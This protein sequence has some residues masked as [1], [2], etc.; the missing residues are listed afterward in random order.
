MLSGDSLR[1]LSPIGD[2]DRGAEKIRDVETEPVGLGDSGALQT[3]RHL[4]GVNP[5]RVA[6]VDV[7]CGALGFQHAHGIVNKIDAFLLQSWTEAAH[8]GERVGLANDDRLAAADSVGESPNP[9]PVRIATVGAACRVLPAVA[10]GN[11]IRDE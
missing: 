5:S 2:V 3:V 7:N 10:T 9:L 11:V 8:S 1:D 6:G 4:R